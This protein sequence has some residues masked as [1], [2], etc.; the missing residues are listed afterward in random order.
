VCAAQIFKKGYLAI[1]FAQDLVDL[2]PDGAAV[3]KRDARPWVQH[4]V[5]GAEMQGT[6]G[7][8]VTEIVCIG[9]V[10]RLDPPE[11]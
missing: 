1:V 2:V 8:V 10:R 4:D 3:E 9:K 5:Q 6:R 7:R 11:V